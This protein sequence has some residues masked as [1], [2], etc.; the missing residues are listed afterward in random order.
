MT[1]FFFPFFSVW[2]GRIIPRVSTKPAVEE[3][4]LNDKQNLPMSHRVVEILSAVDD[5]V[6]KVTNLFGSKQ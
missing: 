3:Y 6:L 2:R 1:F 4:F 5:T